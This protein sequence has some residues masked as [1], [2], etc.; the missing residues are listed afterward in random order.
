[1]HFGAVS[2]LPEFRSNFL[3]LR[4]FFLLELETLEF[5]VP[6]DVPTSE[7]EQLLEAL[8]TEASGLRELSIMADNGLSASRFIV[9]QLPKLNR[10]A[11][12]EIHVGLMRRNIP[13]IQHSRFLQTLELVLQGPF[14][15][16]NVSG[17]MPLELNTLKYLFLIGTRLQDCTSFLLQVA[18]I[19]LSTIDIT[20]RTAA[21]PTKIAAFIKS[22]AASCRTSEFLTRISVVDNSP[23]E[24]E[25]WAPQTPT[26]LHSHIFRPLLKFRSLSTVVFDNIGHYCLDDV[27][28]EDA[29]LAWPGLRELRF[30]SERFYSSAV[31][32]AA[33]LS[34]A[35]KCRSLRT[36]Q[37]TFDATQFPTLP[38]APDGT[39]ELWPTQTALHELHV[40]H[41]SVLWQS[42]LY[43]FLA[44]FFPNLAHLTWYD[45]LGDNYKWG[46]VKEVW[47][48]TVK[49]LKIRPAM[50]A[51][52]Q[53]FL[54]Q[55][56]P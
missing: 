8:P 1:L 7:V 46:K 42:W 35:S 6:V 54:L 51:S 20:Y 52:W 50:V 31:T 45:V 28:I 13:N 29:A 43:L 49:H 21:S 2:D 9:P 36:L 17:H 3:L 32:F 15:M 55:A 25:W 44:V 19:Q 4:Q 10:L 22:L 12:G 14:N 11:I 41:S 26:E 40:A 5:N 39:R 48:S 16:N 18:T 34:L 30:V 24:P 47:E 37:L 33:V 23:R 27:F 38:Y 56:R 53:D